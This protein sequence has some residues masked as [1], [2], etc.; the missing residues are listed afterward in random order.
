[1]ILE[2]EAKRGRDCN[3]SKSLLG[4][5]TLSKAIISGTQ[6]VLNC[7][8]SKSLLGIETNTFK[9][10][11]SITSIAIHQNPRNVEC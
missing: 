3:S 5:E 7:N 8:S 6:E 11:R 2:R 9:I 1:M 4:I 10:D